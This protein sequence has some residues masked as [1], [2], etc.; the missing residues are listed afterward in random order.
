MRRIRPGNVARMLTLILFTILFTFPIIWVFYN[1]FKT[2]TIL[3]ESPWALP[4]VWHW[5][6]YVYA[7]NTAKV[8]IYFLNSIKVCVVALLLT[9]LLSTMASFAL[10]RLKWKLSKAVH[11]VI[12]ACMM[13][14][15]SATLIPQFIMLSKVGMI[16]SHISLSL[17]YTVL[18]MPISI[19]ILTGFMKS[20]PTEIEESAVIDGTSMLRMFLQIT[21]PISK[22][23]IATVAIYVFV[24][25]WNEL[26]YALVFLSD[27]MKM[28]LPYGLKNFQASYTTD[29]VNTFAAVSIAT[30]P[31]VAIFAIF[32]RQIIAGVTAGSIKG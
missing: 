12:M 6:N 10:T 31:T 15:A 27:T 13:I 11:G 16:N 14:P 29:Y 22:T 32:N 7:W 28:T 5:E 19:F 3:Y 1:S 21:I 2:N 17:L 26:T 9:L 30:I 4:E 18:N 24:A 8:G 23:S 25:M 20:F